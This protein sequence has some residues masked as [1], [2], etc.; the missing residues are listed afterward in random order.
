MIRMRMTIMHNSDKDR[1]SCDYRT[2]VILMHFPFRAERQV[3]VHHI[4]D[5]A[6][7][8]LGHRRPGTFCNPARALETVYF[9]FALGYVGLCIRLT[10]RLLWHSTTGTST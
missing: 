9:S 1:G 2:Q 3:D 5:H 8:A 6:G 4:K 7:K 10:A